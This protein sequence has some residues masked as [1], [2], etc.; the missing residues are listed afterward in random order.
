MPTSNLT[1]FCWWKRKFYLKI[2]WIVTFVKFK[3]S[4]PN[5]DSHVPTLR[6]IDFGCAIDMTLFN[7]DQQFKKVRILFI[8]LR[9]RFQSERKIRYHRRSRVGKTLK[10]LRGHKSSIFFDYNIKKALIQKRLEK[11]NYSPT[12]LYITYVD[13]LYGLLK[14]MFFKLIPGHSNWRI[15]VYWNVG[16]PW[17]VISN[18]F[19]LCSRHHSCY[20]IRRVY[21]TQ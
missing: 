6:L 2:C 15:Y 20:V 4:S 14:I 17:V 10:S 18:W 5:I 12:F 9:R 16:R 3:N 7:E 8:Y 21:A 13:F 11:M 1:T 19:I